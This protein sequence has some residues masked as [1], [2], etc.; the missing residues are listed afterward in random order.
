MR[1]L[2]FLFVLGLGIFIGI[3]IA[4]GGLQ[5]TLQGVVTFIEGLQKGRGKE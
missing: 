1:T 5:E 2:W 4:N 3:K